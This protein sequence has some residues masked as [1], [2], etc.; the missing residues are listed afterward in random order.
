MTPRLAKACIE[1]EGLG[2]CELWCSTRGGS[3]SPCFIYLKHNGR[4]IT[5]YEQRLR[6]YQLPL[7]ALFLCLY[8]LDLIKDLVYQRNPLL[9]MIPKD[10][11]WQPVK[12][13]IPFIYGGS[14][15]NA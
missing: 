12:L 1:V 11:T 3:K 8:N 4:I 2:K 9:E 6:G 10:T 13:V 7:T 5:P 14:N 15:G